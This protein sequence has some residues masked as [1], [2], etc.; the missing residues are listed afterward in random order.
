MAKSE[1]EKLFIQH[2]WGDVLEEHSGGLFQEGS[3]L[4]FKALIREAIRRASIDDIFRKKYEEEIASFYD[5][6]EVS[7]EYGEGEY[8]S[9][10]QLKEYV[11]KEHV[12]AAGLDV[13][14]VNDRLI[15]ILSERR[16]EDP[17]VKVKTRIEQLASEL[18]SARRDL[19]KLAAKE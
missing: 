4:E 13:D 3:L 5:I 10:R 18:E 19:E 16:G 1:T 15:E 7:H 11:Y 6:G 12:L 8:P 2:G 9:P 17:I 14:K